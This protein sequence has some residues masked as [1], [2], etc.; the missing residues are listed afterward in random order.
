MMRIFSQALNLTPVAET[1]SFKEANSLGLSFEG[2]PSPRSQLVEVMM[3]PS[4]KFS[5]SDS[6]D[7]SSPI[8]DRGESETVE[9]SRHP[10]FVQMFK[11]PYEG[12]NTVP[13]QMTMTSRTVFYISLLLFFQVFPLFHLRGT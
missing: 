8:I 4:T 10:K 1:M 12:L 11:F 6:S 2:E 9:N 7:V 3:P 13:P 5:V